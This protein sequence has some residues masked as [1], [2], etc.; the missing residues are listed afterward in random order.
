MNLDRETLARRVYET[1]HITGHFRLRSGTISE[2][3][4]DKYLFESDPAL[5]Q[6]IARHL[7]T[8]VP[9]GI[10]VIAGLE[11]GGVPLATMISQAT[12]LPLVLVRKKAKDY[13]TCKLAEGCAIRGRKLLVVEDVVTTAGQII[14]SAKEL[15]Q[16]GAEIERVVCVIDREAGGRANLAAEGLDFHAL[17]T[18]SEIKSLAGANQ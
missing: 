10:E 5:L 11:L 15:R 16:L 2:E 1:S 14:A 13:G 9:R 6:E 3:Y 12:S 4:F 7:C 18:M 8:L 17:F